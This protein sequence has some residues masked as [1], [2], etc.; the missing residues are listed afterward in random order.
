[1]IESIFWSVFIM[2]IWF[3]TDAFCQ[4]FPFLS[5]VKEWND[6]RIK[7]TDI[8]FPNFLFLRNPNFWTKLIS[9]QPCLL[10][11]IVILLS[12]LFGF[13]YFPVKWAISYFIFRVISKV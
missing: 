6:Y 3:K 7:N 1:M 12:F 8:S 11:W 10:F 9:C 2:F 5:K 4:Y 13:S